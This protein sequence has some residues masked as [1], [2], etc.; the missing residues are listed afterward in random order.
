MLR[1]LV[2]RVSTPDE[3]FTEGDLIESDH[4]DDDV[5]TW[6]L[7]TGR[8]EEVDADLSCPECGKPYTAQG[9]LDRHIETEHGDESEES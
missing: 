5:R 2:R 4:F 8:V 1:V 3:A 9:W 7:D 6:L